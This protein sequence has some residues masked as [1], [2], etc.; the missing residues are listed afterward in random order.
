MT[1]P[2]AVWRGNRVKVL[3]AEAKSVVIVTPLGYALRVRQTEVAV[4][5]GRKKN[6]RDSRKF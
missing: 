4:A 1:E 3:K 5:T 2:Q 6:L